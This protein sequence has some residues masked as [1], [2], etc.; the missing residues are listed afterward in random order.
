MIYAQ[1]SALFSQESI[2]S[3]FCNT[4]NRQADKHMDSL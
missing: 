4:T 2:L 1:F 3:L